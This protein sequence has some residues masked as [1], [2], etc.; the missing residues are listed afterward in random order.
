LT[1]L[2]AVSNTSHEEHAL[3]ETTTFGSGR[4][5]SRI[6]IEEE[7]MEVKDIL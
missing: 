4:N 6:R 3:F 5:E 2:V 7:V 1:G